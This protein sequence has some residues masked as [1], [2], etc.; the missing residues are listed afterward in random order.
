MKGMRSLWFDL[1]VGRYVEHDPEFLVKN[2]SL[3]FTEPTVSKEYEKQHEQKT[4]SDD[5]VPF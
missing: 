2:P 4:R 5:E 3:D 1:E